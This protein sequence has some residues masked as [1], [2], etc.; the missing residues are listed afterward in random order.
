MR[1]TALTLYYYVLSLEDTAS[2]VRVRRAYR[3]LT[4][5]NYPDKGGSAAAL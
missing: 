2:I 3:R 5:A 1:S 4:L